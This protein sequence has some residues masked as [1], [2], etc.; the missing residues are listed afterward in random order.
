MAA[1]DP[2]EEHDEDED[3]FGNETVAQLACS[4]PSRRA[5]ASFPTPP[6][7][8]PM[9]F[10]PDTPATVSRFRHAQ[11]ATRAPSHVGVQ[12]SMPDPELTARMEEVDSLKREVSKLTGTLDS[13][14][15]VVGRLNQ[16]LLEDP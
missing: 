7:T 4:T 10:A 11:T 5:R 12:A 16:R 3:M 2:F 1:R 15:T 13:Y 8:S 9:A 6:A 14:K